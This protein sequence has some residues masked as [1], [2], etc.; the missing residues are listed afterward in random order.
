MTPGVL[1]NQNEKCNTVCWGRG[2]TESLKNLAC[3]KK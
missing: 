2:E 1:K 3:N